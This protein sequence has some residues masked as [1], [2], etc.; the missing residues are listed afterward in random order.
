VAQLASYG[1]TIPLYLTLQLWTSPTIPGAQRDTILVHP[2]QAILIP[3]SIALGYVVPVALLALP[4]SLCISLDQ[5]QTLLA[6]W[7]AFP[8][9]VS[10]INFVLSTLGG[11]FFSG[12][13]YTA[14]TNKITLSST[15]P[16][17]AFAFTL[18]TITHIASWS[19]SLSSLLFPTI[20]SLDIIGD[21][22]PISVFLPGFSQ[23]HTEWPLGIHRL[24]QWDN[25]VG[26]T[27]IL[28]W[29]AVVWSNACR[30][31]GAK[32]NLP[33]ALKIL[34]LSVTSGF[35]GAAVVLQWERDKV[36][37]TD[38]RETRNKQ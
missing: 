1:V 27:A 22:S 31:I 17:Y 3:Y 10:L 36:L 29:A 38:K 20:Y 12:P 25:F 35:V 30:V 4:N 18:A 15:R 7:N 8:L 6:V 14:Y 37:L 23:D 16:I 13:K 11:A 5:K 19:I 34:G 32:S 24:L 33:L 2:L 26:S 9:L 28:A 21:L